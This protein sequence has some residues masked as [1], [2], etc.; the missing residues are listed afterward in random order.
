MET[1]THQEDPNVDVYIKARRSPVSDKYADPDVEA[2]GKHWTMSS[3]S[4]ISIIF[5]NSLMVSSAF[6]VIYVIITLRTS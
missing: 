3:D 5:W 4:G 2:R 6:S 1:F